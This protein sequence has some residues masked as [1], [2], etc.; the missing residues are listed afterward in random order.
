[1]VFFMEFNKVAAGCGD[2][3]EEKLTVLCMLDGAL[4]GL[5]KDLD[6]LRSAGVRQRRYG[7]K[8]NKALQYNFDLL[9]TLS[10]LAQNGVSVT[11]V[12][13]VD[14][15]RLR[16]MTH[17]EKQNLNK[18]NLNN[19]RELANKEG[20][21]IRTHLFK[22]VTADQL[23]KMKEQNGAER[24]FTYA[25]CADPETPVNADV[26]V[27]VSQDLKSREF[28]YKA[29]FADPVKFLRRI[30]GVDPYKPPIIPPSLV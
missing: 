20:Y 29:S 11:I 16:E 25:F 13:N 28:I 6:V 4:I 17:Q 27:I 26:A 22:V 24:K 8:D 21:T 14:R 23:S 7:R 12:N 5:E 15:S 3:N 30:S 19:M 18:K 2:K 1:M 10:D 9:Q